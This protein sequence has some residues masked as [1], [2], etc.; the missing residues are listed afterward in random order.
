MC[1]NDSSIN[2]PTRLETELRPIPITHSGT[3]QDIHYRLPKPRPAPS[4]S[5]QDKTG[6]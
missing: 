4:R 1:A 5:R 3:A 2:Y 6:K